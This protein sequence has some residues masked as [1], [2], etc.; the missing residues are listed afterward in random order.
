LRE[1][2]EL[3]G[4]FR[5][6]TFKLLRSASGQ[7]WHLCL[8]GNIKMIYVIINPWFSLMDEDAKSSVK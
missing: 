4:F 6:F 2:C 5:G 8:A 7:K 1:L 3:Q